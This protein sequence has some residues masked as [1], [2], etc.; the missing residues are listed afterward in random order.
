MLF[1]AGIIVLAYALAIMIPTVATSDVCRVLHAA[2]V[3]ERF[4]PDLNMLDAIGAK[5]MSPDV[6]FGNGSR[7][8]DVADYWVTITTGP[9][10]WLNCQDKTIRKEIYFP[11][12]LI[13]RPVRDVRFD[14][15]DLTIFQTEY[16]LNVIIDTKA[17]APV[18][19]KASYVFADANTIYGVCKPGDSACDMFREPRPRKAQGDD[20]PYFSA[21]K[22][23]LF[24]PDPAMVAKAAQDLRSLQDAQDQQTSASAGSA[25]QTAYQDDPACQPH[26][27]FLYRP[28]KKFETGAINNGSEYPRPVRFTLCTRDPAGNLRYRKLKF[29]TPEFAEQR[30]AG[31]WTV[32]T[33]NL[34][35]KDVLNSLKQ[36]V[37]YSNQLVTEISCGQPLGDDLLT[38]S[39]LAGSPLN[40]GDTANLSDIIAGDAAA[41]A[42]NRE[43]HIRAYETH[44]GLSDKEE[45]YSAP[46]FQDLELKVLCSDDLRVIRPERIRI[47]ARQLFGAE[48]LDI[49]LNDLNADYDRLYA[50]YGRP[51]DRV[52]RERLEN[53]QLFRIC[54]LIEYM[55]WRDLL[56][57]DFLDLPGLEKTAKGLGVGKVIL[58]D[59]MAHLVMATFFFTEAAI[60]TNPDR[61]EER[62]VS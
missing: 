15:R 33:A 9:A 56:R 12:G 18:H 59:H 57:R 4:P 49:S 61:E 2:N 45:I 48:P 35:D 52:A 43:L 3:D 5:D 25:R 7:L 60:I 1:R 44:L 14:S 50:K 38:L 40:S 53:G 8:T 41:D 58:A 62:C 20:W 28:Y 23:Y 32:S 36:S 29:V 26:A 27:A 6:K 16:G 13:L 19:D 54:D 10:S 24:S 51:P 47:Q 11:I 39:A 17:V 31:L 30:F 46:L 37:Q 22:G 34:L 42:T 21:N 55:N